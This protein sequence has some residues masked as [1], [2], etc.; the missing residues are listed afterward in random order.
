MERLTSLIYAQQSGETHENETITL[1][2]T[3]KAKKGSNLYASID[4]R[5]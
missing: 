1:L 4:C 3:K 2:L 5:A